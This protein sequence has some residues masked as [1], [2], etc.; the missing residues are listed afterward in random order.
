MTQALRFDLLLRLL[1][2]EGMDAD[3]P[4]SVMVHLLQFRQMIRGRV[5]PVIAMADTERAHS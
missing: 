1:T 4:F 5:S 3:Q 2:G